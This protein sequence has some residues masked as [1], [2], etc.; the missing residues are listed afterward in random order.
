MKLDT[1]R[2]DGAP[3]TKVITD[4]GYE[5]LFYRL[6]ASLINIR[7]GADYLLRS[8][9]YR[10]DFHR[11][12]CYHGKTIG[13]T[14]NRLR[15]HKF[16]IEDQNYDFANN[17]GENVHHGG[18]DGLSNHFFDLDTSFGTNYIDLIFTYLSPH[19]ES[20]YPG[21][22]NV[23][24]TYRIYDKGCAYDI[25]YE[26]NSDLDTLLN[27]TNHA[28]FTLGSKN[29]N[30]L[31]LKV[32]GHKYLEVDEELIPIEDRDLIPA[33][34][35]REF[36]NLTKDIEDPSINWGRLQGY[37]HFLFFDN[38]SLYVTNVSLRN[39]KYQLDIQTDFQGVQIYT[40][41]HEFPYPL[42]PNTNEVRNAVAIEPCDNYL[43]FRYQR[44]NETYLRTIRYQ[45]T[46]RSSI[47]DIEKIENKFT[48]IFKCKSDKVFS[49]GGRFE[50]LGNHT[51]HNHGLCLAATCNLNIVASVK[52]IDATYG[53]VVFHSS[54][55]P[56]DIVK[57]DT[58]APQDDEKGTSRGLIRGIAF[59]LKNHGYKVG[60]FVAYSESNIFSGAGLSSSAAF[61]LLIGQIFNNLYNN[62]E[63]PTIE[64]CKAGQYAENKYFGKAS[65]LL[66]QIGVGYGNISYID[67]KNIESPK[68]EQITWPFNDLHFLIINTG[69]SHAQLSDLYSAIPNDMYSAA[70][71]SGVEYL[72]DIPYKELDKSQLTDSEYSRAYHFYSENERVFKAVRA[73]KEKDEETFL[74]MINESRLSSTNY[75]KNM[76]VENKYEG[77]PLEACGLFMKITEGRGAIK[78]N[79]GGFAG[80][81]IAVVP[82]DLLKPVMLEMQSKYGQDNVCEVFV[83]GQG[84]TIEK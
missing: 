23:K 43:S 66:D 18:L 70:K 40:S 38:P 28:F 5:F 78:I 64:L 48:E 73:I 74:R 52:K 57:L 44:K 69:G 2:I 20:G 63:I 4:D 80:S 56:V 54:N 47:M 82:T 71:K 1:V 19:L 55:Y 83:R 42:F 35:F 60:P 34:D 15:G 61:E 75:L 37:D 62:D 51:D 49:C 84:P 77:S 30:D 32:N 7:H 45:I 76:M 25:Y 29:I 8:V 13:R 3:Y 79:G 27:L 59:Y 11:K 67:F 39:N 6:G 9:F 81:V 24:V 50:I 53:R 72:R 41:N 26:A 22:L 12:D 65:G 16:K 10:R 68:V 58:F 17:E 21:N 33:L 46:E 31:Y 36:K 14:A